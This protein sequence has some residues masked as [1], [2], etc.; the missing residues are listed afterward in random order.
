M[1]EVRE[2]YADQHKAGN[3]FPLH[4]HSRLGQR[5]I[6]A[7]HR[8]AAAALAEGTSCRHWWYD[9]REAHMMISELLWVG[10]GPESTSFGPIKECATAQQ[11]LDVMN[12]L[13]VAVVPTTDVARDVLRLLGCDEAWVVYATGGALLDGDTIDL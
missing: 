12:D 3:R 13:N 10:R 7:G 9:T 6:L 1:G 2:T 4:E 11:A 8:R 5:V